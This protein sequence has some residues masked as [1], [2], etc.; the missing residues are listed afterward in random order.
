MRLNL[1]FLGI[2]KCGEAAPE[3]LLELALVFAGWSSANAGAGALG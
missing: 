3:R 2:E 1:R